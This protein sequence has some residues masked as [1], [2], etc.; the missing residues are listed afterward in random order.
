MIVE[1]L[2]ATSASG[3]NPAT[4]WKWS[5][6]NMFCKTAQTFAAGKIHRS[7]DIH[8]CAGCFSCFERWTGSR[9]H[10][11]LRRWEGTG[12]DFR[13]C[14]PESKGYLALEDAVEVCFSL[15]WRTT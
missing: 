2:G 14:D 3:L 12:S 9:K 7:G 4:W 10:P 13:Q 11:I 1:T 6:T 15:S 8:G 5:T